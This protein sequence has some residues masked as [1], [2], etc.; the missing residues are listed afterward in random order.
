[1]RRG[2][3]TLMLA[4]LGSLSS[5]VHAQVA[6]DAS[7]NDATTNDAS[8]NDAS[9]DT[10]R[11]AGARAATASGA[12]R[13]EESDD[14]PRWLV[15]QARYD[16]VIGWASRY[17]LTTSPDPLGLEQR[18]WQ[19]VD[20]LPFYHRLSVN[21]TLRLDRGVALSLHFSGWG[22]ANLLADQGGGV[23]AGDVV[24]GY[25]ELDVAPPGTEAPISLWVGRR[26]VAHGPP[27]GIQLDGGGARVGS[28]VGVFAELFVG[29]PVTATRSS[30]LGPEPSFEGA[31]VAYG[32]RVGYD[33]PGVFVASAA[34]AE[35]WGRGMLGSRT[36]DVTSLWDPGPVSLE[37]SLKLDVTSPAVVLARL[38]VSAP[39]VRE[40]SVDLEGQHLEPARWIPPWSI[41]SAFE[42]STFEEIAGGATVRIAPG[43]AARAQGAARLYVGEV[44]GE[45]RVGYRAEALVRLVPVRDESSTT[46]RVLASRRDDGVLGYT[47]IT[48]GL[49]SAPVPA[50]RVAIDG[51]LAVDDAADRLSVSGRASLDASPGAEWTIGAWASV[52]RTPTTDADVRA[53]LRARW[54]P[55]L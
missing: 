43:L 27:G 47:L 31:G 21:G 26:F 32:A 36:V 13:V 34:Y 55:V 10:S 50:V 15:A 46:F 18:L 48:A 11:D 3:A 45:V 6:T 54:E 35:L 24:L 20:V 9:D 23:A 17:Q 29:R 2:L 41:L 12:T 16:A 42:A 51:A 33:D 39:I 44:P 14:G 30:L 38:A 37:G 28:R 22:T 4:A 7:A 5:R 40:L 19:R 49:S 1:M 53:M 25:L 52:A 8:T